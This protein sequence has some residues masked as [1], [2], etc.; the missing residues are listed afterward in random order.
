MFWRP[1]RVFETSQSMQRCCLNFD[2]S[3]T[4]RAATLQAFV[5]SFTNKANR[6]CSQRKN[7]QRIYNVGIGPP[8]RAKHLRCVYTMVC[9]CV[10]LCVL[11][12]LSLAHDANRWVTVA[13]ERTW[14][15]RRERTSLFKPLR[16]TVVSSLLSLVSDHLCSNHDVKLLAQWPNIYLQRRGRGRRADKQPRG[17]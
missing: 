5:L 1:S 12:Q 6:I 14:E 16:Q 9:V 7:Q 8:G 10:H 13:E 15:E 17:H 11:W 4:S 2:L 3:Y